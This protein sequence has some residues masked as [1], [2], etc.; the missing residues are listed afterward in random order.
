MSEMGHK[1]ETGVSLARVARGPS[2]SLHLSF[3]G[4]ARLPFTARIGRDCRCSVQARSLIHLGMAPALVRLRP[5][6][7]HIL[8]VRAPGARDHAGVVP[9][10][11]IWPPLP[12]PA[13]IGPIRRNESGQAK[14]EISPHFNGRQQT[15]GV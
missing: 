7:E 2:D 13:M 14:V 6:S 12:R 4:V 8:I 11:P 9:F 1:G 5:S 3:R 15:L 10:R